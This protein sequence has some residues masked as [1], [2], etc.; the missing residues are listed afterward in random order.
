MAYNKQEND[1][2]FQ[3]FLETSHTNE[4]LIAKQM[5]LAAQIDN[6]LKKSGWTRKKL[7]EQSGLQPS[8]ITEILSGDA[9][10][11]LHTIVKLEEA[12][13]KS[14]I[15]C[16]D[17][18]K[19]DLRND[20]WLHPEETVNLVSDQSHSEKFKEDATQINL[21]ENWGGTMKLK[22]G[23]MTIINKFGKAS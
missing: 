22:N 7:A 3:N 19:E 10:P 11:T 18:H 12:F 2:I 14:I 1:R 16:P 8:Q 13:N 5:D 17:L 21:K 23:H 15:V 4:R 20:G 6:Y 9:N